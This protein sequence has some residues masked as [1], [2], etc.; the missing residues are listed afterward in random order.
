MKWKYELYKCEKMYLLAIKSVYLCR[1]KVPN[2]L[3]GEYQEAGT[4]HIHFRWF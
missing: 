4:M 1:T 3:S 2:G